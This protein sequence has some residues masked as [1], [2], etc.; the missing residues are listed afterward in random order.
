MWAG[1]RGYEV[2]QT[3]W[4]SSFARR[5]ALRARPQRTAF[6]QGLLTRIHGVPDVRAVGAAEQHAGRS[7]LGHASHFSLDRHGLPRS[8]AATSRRWPPQC[9]AGLLHRERHRLA[10]RPRLHR[11]GR[12]TGSGDRRIAWP[13]ARPGDTPASLVGRTIRQGTVDAPDITVVGVVQDVR[14]GALDRDLPPQLY[15]PHHQAPSGRMSVLVR[16]AQD[17]SALSAS[18]RDSR[19]RADR[20]FPSPRCARWKKS[21]P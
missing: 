14:P 11:T 6:D 2:K 21:C 1:D 3:C 15:R 8:R 16:T 9:D 10:C 19:R 4:R 12:H 7:G 20:L 17:P 13:S 18:L 5:S